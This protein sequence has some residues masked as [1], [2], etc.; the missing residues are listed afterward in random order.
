LHTA[1]HSNHPPVALSSVAPSVQQHACHCL[2]AT[3]FGL[4]SGS[5]R[6][7]RIAAGTY[8]CR[9]VPIHAL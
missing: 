7:P 2:A 4:F 6:D 9:V 8:I 1:S 3:S 5:H